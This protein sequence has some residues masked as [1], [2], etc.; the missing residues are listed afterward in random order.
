MKLSNEGP[1]LLVSA[2]MM[3]CIINRSLLL[4]YEDAAEHIVNSDYNLDQAQF[5]EGVEVDFL[6]GVNTFE[7]FPHA[8][9]SLRD[10][11]FL[12]ET[13]LKL[14]SKERMNHF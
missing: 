3:D 12:V 14:K 5:A 4:K 2:N 8:I 6:L 10:N 7:M 13:T 9:V 11:L 1:D